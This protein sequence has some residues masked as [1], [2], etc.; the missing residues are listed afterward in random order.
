MVKR[1]IKVDYTKADAFFISENYTKLKDVNVRG[2]VR[3][4]R[5]HHND[6]YLL[7]CFYNLQEK[8]DRGQQDFSKECYEKLQDFVT[9]YLLQKV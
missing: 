7:Q 4:Y 5:N 6:R 9:Q 2:I 1:G 8:Y 3:C